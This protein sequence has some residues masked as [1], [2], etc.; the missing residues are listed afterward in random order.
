MADK[1][2]TIL[3][4]AKRAGVTDATVSRALRNSPLVRERTRERVWQAAR[5][6]NYRTN[7]AG[8][9]LVTGKTF[10]IGLI[11]PSLQYPLN[12]NV[13]ECIQHVVGEKNYGLLITSLE[14]HDE[15]TMARLKILS[16][17]CVDG[18]ILQPAM[19]NQDIS[20]IEIIRQYKIPFVVSADVPGY[21]VTFP[22][23]DNFDGA[24]Q[25]TDHVLK[26]GYRRP[27]LITSYAC[28]AATPHLVQG[29]QKKL[30]QADIPLKECPI[31][32][33]E[34]F[35]TTS[36]RRT[37]DSILE[38]SRSVDCLLIT[39]IVVAMQAYLYLKKKGVEIGPKFGLAVGDDTAWFAENCLSIT[40]ISYPIQQI[41]QTLVEMLLR[42]IEDPNAP[43]ET[44]YF[45]GTLTARDSTTRTDGIINL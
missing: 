25:L 41:A 7:T 42:R 1:T 6:L 15:M 19:S 18:I 43:R 27:A 22:S 24:Y 14:N 36:I 34:E 37:V 16:E 17:H 31:V 12:A 11:T 35:D 23:F 32:H 13:A 44:Q 40:S 8:R 33:Q 30:Q 5:E 2:V 3:E 20:C 39:D 10:T 45:K 26:Q 38:G 4:I 9:G 21:D 28:H 29:F